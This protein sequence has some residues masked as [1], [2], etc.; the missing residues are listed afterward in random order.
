MIKN[1]FLSSRLNEL[2]KQYPQKIAVKSETR[3]ISYLDLERQSNRIAN[4][5]HG[6]SLHCEQYEIPFSLAHSKV[7]HVPGRIGHLP[8]MFLQPSQGNTCLGIPFATSNSI[9][10]LL[11]RL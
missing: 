6:K 7:A 1:E 11:F 8:L 4:F 3:R 2:V 10:C 9:S 5:M